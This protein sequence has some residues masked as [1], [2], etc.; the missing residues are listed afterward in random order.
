[1]KSSRNIIFLFIVVTGLLA[2]RKDKP[3]LNH[4]STN[5]N[6]WLD[7]LVCMDYPDSIYIYSH[8]WG[9][10]QYRTPYFNPNNSNEFIYSYYDYEDNIQQLI[11]YNL[12]TKQKLILANLGVYKQPKWGRNGWIAF[13]NLHHVH[14]IRENGS[15]YRQVTNQDQN[16]SPFWHGDNLYWLNTNPSG[17]S[18]TVRQNIN[19]P[20]IDTV[21]EEL[22]FINNAV[23]NDVILVKGGSYSFNGTPLFNPSNFTSISGWP[24]NSINGLTWHPS[25]EFFYTSHFFGDNK[26]ERGLFKITLSGQSERIMEYCQSKR[27]SNISCSSDGKYII[28]ERTAR[29][30]EQYDPYSGRLIQNSTIWL[31]NTETMEETKIDLE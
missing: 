24:N 28:G 12:V 10:Y 30:L 15:G 25:G 31:I 5:N 14:V 4:S 23:L 22:G 9:R 27:Y 21:T 8:A 19:N 16:I 2:C 6:E 20:S 17:P 18:F 11:K 13:S 7:T 3:I 1:M 29:S 26:D